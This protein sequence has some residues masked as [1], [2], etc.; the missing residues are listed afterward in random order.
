MLGYGAI[1]IFI[2]ES[3]N[4]VEHYGLQRKKDKNGIYESINIMHSW[5]SPQRYSNYILFKLQRHSDHHANAYKPYQ[6]LDTFEESP[7]LFGGYSLALATG[8]FPP[9]FHM[10]YGPEALAAREYK[11]VSKEV[12]RQGERIN[13]SYLGVIGVALGIICYLLA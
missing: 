12:R 6:I 3:I 5:N 9:I 13:Y 2:Q 8:V 10:V 11:T 7:Q 4:Y 1:G